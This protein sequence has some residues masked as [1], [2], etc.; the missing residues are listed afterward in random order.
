[1]SVYESDGRLT[2][3]IVVVVRDNGVFSDINASGEPNQ[4]A[5]ARESEKLFLKTLHRDDWISEPFIMDVQTRHGWSVK[6]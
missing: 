6:P 4:Y 1:V 3:G 5:V 2:T